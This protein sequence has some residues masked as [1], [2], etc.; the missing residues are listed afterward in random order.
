MKEE[1][2]IY[3]EFWYDFASSYSYLATVQIGAWAQVRGIAVRWRP[4]LL[5]PTFESQGWNSSP[6]NIFKRKG[7]YM[8][9]DMERCAALYGLTF[10]KPLH[11]FPQNGLLAARVALCLP[12]G[13][14]RGTFTK[15]VF[16]AEFAEGKD[17][18]EWGTVVRILEDMAQDASVILPQ[19]QSEFIKGILRSYTK[20]AE[21]KRIFGV[22]SFVTPDGE[23][24]WGHDR[25][26]QALNWC[27]GDAA[28]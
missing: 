25:L 4:F 1:A 14:Q 3:L 11:I 16:Q 26:E 7:D 6:F 8:W 19:S 2:E 23:L 17:I 21:S 15:R 18:A 9:R 22:P 10:Q 27:S 28:R 24:F 20:E 5:G 12:D 13:V